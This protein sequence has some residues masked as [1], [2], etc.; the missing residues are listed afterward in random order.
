[1]ELKIVEENGVVTF[2]VKGQL[3]TT[4][5]SDFEETLKPYLSSQA[6]LIFDF[7]A[8][9]YLSSAGLRVILRTQQKAEELNSSLVIRNSNEDVM[10]VFEITGF[11]DFL[12]FV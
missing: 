4:T 9:E 2:F 7:E 1:M 8:L 12:T 11:A 3:D 5:F 6:N 10:E